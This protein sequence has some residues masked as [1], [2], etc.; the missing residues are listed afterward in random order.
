MRECLL[1]NLTVWICQESALDER[2]R[3]T[4]VSLYIFKNWCVIEAEAQV[5]S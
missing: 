5:D 3:D 1:P 2:G 4:Q